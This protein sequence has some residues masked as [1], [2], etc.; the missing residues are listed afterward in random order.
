[1]L[2]SSLRFRLHLVVAA[3]LPFGALGAC[4]GADQTG[5]AGELITCSTDP[6]TGVILRCTPGGGGG[7][8]TDVDEDGDGD[9]HDDPTIVKS[10]TDGGGGG[11]DDGSGGTADDDDGDGVPNA[12]DCDERPGEDGDDHGGGGEAE[13]PYDVKPQLDATVTPILDAF[14]AEGVAPASIDSVTL[15]GGSWR[16]AELQA[17][18]P[19]VVTPDDCN[20]AGNRDVGRDRVIVTWTNADGTSA[21]DHLDIRY[22]EQ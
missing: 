7:T 13:L 4:T 8:C 14:A 5:T 10:R 2:N 1:M 17:G 6:G 21:S 20:H 19:F 12:E 18:A 9:C 15:D 22:C 11:S 3:L 16:L